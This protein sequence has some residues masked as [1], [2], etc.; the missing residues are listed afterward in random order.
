MNKTDRIKEEAII[1][2]ITDQC[3]LN[4]RS[5]LEKQSE[6]LKHQVILGPEVRAQL[7]SLFMDLPLQMGEI[8][9]DKAF[10]RYG[11]MIHT[12]YGITRGD[13]ICLSVPF[14][15]LA[16]PTDKF[17]WSTAQHRKYY[18]VAVEHGTRLLLDMMGF[19]GR[20]RKFCSNG[21]KCECLIPCG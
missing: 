19:R 6:G 11:D 18:C 20:Q 17:W 5:H 7:A 8:L 10:E 4:V 9:E 3:A 12:P 2:A 16:Y 15:A 1:N 21:T 14:A 13:A